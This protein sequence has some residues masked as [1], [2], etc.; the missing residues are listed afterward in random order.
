MLERTVKRATRPIVT[1]ACTELVTCVF[2]AAV[3]VSFL[4]R[5]RVS[6]LTASWALAMMLNPD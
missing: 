6:L 5:T 3:G 4:P 2:A 1:G